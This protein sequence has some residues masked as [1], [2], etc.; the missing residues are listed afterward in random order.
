LLPPKNGATV[1]A[2]YAS[3]LGRH[4]HEAVRWEG[5]SWM[6]IEGGLFVEAWPFWDPSQLQPRRTPEG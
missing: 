6:R 5:C 2:L 1:F 4:S 3:R